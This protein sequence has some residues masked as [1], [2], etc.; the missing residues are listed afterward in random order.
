M[1]DV[2]WDPFDIM[3]SRLGAK[4]AW[5]LSDHGRSRDYCCLY[6]PP[7]LT[8]TLRYP[9]SQVFARPLIRQSG[10]MSQHRGLHWDNKS[11]RGLK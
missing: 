2:I 3:L 6:W 5:C 1:K 11:R 10:F 4:F 7:L 9:A 8:T